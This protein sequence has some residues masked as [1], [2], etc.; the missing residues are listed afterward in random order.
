MPEQV[1]GAASEVQDFGALDEALLSAGLLEGV[2]VGHPIGA[3]TTYRVGGA[4]ARFVRPADVAELE[5]VVGA[6]A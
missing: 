6:V 5:R 2:R 4:A 3:L 1:P